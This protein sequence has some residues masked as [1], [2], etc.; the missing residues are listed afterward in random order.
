[1][2]PARPHAAVRLAFFR[3]FRRKMFIGN[4]DIF[5]SN[6]IWNTRIHALMATFNVRRVTNPCHG[7][8]QNSYFEIDWY[9]DDKQ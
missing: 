3:F 9:I 5:T 4:D 1:M 6:F 8:G 2:L 7:M